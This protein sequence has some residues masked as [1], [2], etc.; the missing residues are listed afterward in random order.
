MYA[1]VLAPISASPG[2]MKTDDQQTAQGID[3]GFRES[4]E[5]AGSDAGMSPPFHATRQ[6]EADKTVFAKAKQFV[7]AIFSD[8]AS[9]EPERRSA[10]VS[11]VHKRRVRNYDR[12]S[13]L[14]ALEKLENHPPP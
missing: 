8:E 13:G 4:N 1:A 12:V 3:A 10:G 2:A 14:T 7:G 5:Q 11:G 9:H 6:A